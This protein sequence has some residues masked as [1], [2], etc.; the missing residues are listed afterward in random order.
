MMD[1]LFNWSMDACVEADLADLQAGDAEKDLSR[2]VR[3]P[4]TSQIYPGLPGI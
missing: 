3:I 2:S 4:L 1:E